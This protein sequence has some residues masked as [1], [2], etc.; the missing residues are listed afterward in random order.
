MIFFVFSPGDINEITSAADVRSRRR[1]VIVAINFRSEIRPPASSDRRR[2]NGIA[3]SR[4]VLENDLNGDPTK[5]IK[6][7]GPSVPIN[8]IAFRGQKVRRNIYIYIFFTY[9]FLLPN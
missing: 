2:L 3:L 6:D 5:P 8:V 9:V 7:K 1:D 4:R